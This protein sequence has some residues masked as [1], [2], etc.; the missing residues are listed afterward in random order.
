MKDP[1]NKILKRATIAEEYRA[2]T[3]LKGPKRSSQINYGVLNAS[4]EY[5]LRVDSDMTA[6]VNVVKKYL[7]LCKEGADAV[8]LPVLPRPSTCNNFWV[9]CRVLE[10][11]MLIDDMINV[12]PRFIRRNVFLAVRGYDERIVAW[13]DYDPHNRSLNSGYKV[14]LLQDSALPDSIPAWLLKIRFK[15]AKWIAGFYLF[16]PNPFSKESPYKGKRLL[17]GLLYCLSQIPV[18]WLAKKYADMVWVTNE[19][20]RWR[21]IDN[22]KLMPDRVI[23]VRGGVDTKTPVLIPEPK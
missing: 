3:L 21:F 8:V 20:D 5:V 19:S 14:A 22:R 1:P 23:A 2:K 15:R 18:Y 11:K 10:Q 12:A 7:E 17:T 4:G 13:E 6:D 16:A 9:N